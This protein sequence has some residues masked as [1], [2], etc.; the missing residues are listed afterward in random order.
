MT[1]AIV[2][3]YIARTP[4]GG[5]LGDFK[6]TSATQLG[7]AALRAAV[8]RAGI[9]P[10]TIEE[11]Y[12]G[13]VLS[14][15]LGQAPARQAALGAG[16]GAHTPCTAVSKVCGSGLKA[17]MLAHDSIIAGTATIIAAGGME[18]MTR[19]P[20]L[21]ANARQDKNLANLEDDEILELVREHRI[22]LTNRAEALATA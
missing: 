10:D 6:D 2:I 22:E 19:A 7:A 14:A 3:V 1:D 17:V 21:L 18:N 4:I 8:T 20:H 9:T 15:G 5:L 16:L 11:V 12:M 13:C